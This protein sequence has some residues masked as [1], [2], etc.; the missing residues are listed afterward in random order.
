MT[1]AE[2]T[3]LLLKALEPWA[4]SNAGSVKVA[5]DK[6]HLF[7]LLG[8]NPGA[9]RVAVYFVEERPRSRKFDDIAGRVDRTFW[10]CVSRGRGFNAALGKSLT[11]GVA[12]GKPM[13]VLV[14]EAREEARA[15][16]QDDIDESRPYYKGTY[17]I[18][19]EDATVDAYYV[20]IVLA[21]EIPQQN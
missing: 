13:F 16:R 5:N 12:G 10:I 18:D 1:I 21:A 14:E 17:P 2:Q 3:Q 6:P 8:A 15:V 11:E 19:I 4:V 9:P 20:E 7:Q